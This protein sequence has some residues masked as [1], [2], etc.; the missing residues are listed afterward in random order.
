MARRPTLTAPK[1]QKVRRISRTEQYLVNYKYMGDEPIYTNKELNGLEYIQTL[2]WYNTMCTNDEAR[3]YLLTFLTDS[4]MREEAKL[5]SRVPDNAL[6]T[7]ICWIARLMTRGAI[8]SDNTLVFFNDRLTSMFDRIRN[9][10]VEEKPEVNIQERIRNIKNEIIGQIEELI[11]KNEPFS[12][13]EWL[14]ANNIPATYCSFIIEK[15]SPW[16]GELIEAHEGKDKDLKEAYGYMTKKEL[17]ER[18]LFFNKLITDAE[19]YSD[20]KKKT[21]APRKKKAIPADKM[22]KNLK[23]QKEDNTFK[24]ASIAPEK[25][26]GAEELWTFNTKYKTLTVLRSKTREGLQVKGTSITN[27]DEE[28]SVTKRTG[29]KGSDYVSKVMSG[30]KVVL[31]KIMDEL[32]NTASLAYRINENTILLRVS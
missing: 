16:L 32:K 27:Y 21:R 20:V 12:L 6:N 23:Y 25:I 30:G 2:N 31:R 28:T 10:K 19:S 29:H 1:K 8:L 14:K 15:Y 7:T 3:E 11:D 4:K 24:I 9:K 26:I 5:L 17:K 22:I 18:I 13:Y